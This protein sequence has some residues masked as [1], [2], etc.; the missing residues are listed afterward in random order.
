MEKTCFSGCRNFDDGK[1]KESKSKGV[2]ECF[3][4]RKDGK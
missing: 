3:K 1:A 4:L 2:V